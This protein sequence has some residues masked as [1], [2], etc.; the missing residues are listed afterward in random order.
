MKNSAHILI[1]GGGSG[2]GNGLACRLLKRGGNISVLDLAVSSDYRQALDAAAKT[3]QGNWAFFEIDICDAEKVNK[4]VN[5]A[6]TKFGDIQLAINSA[7]IAVNQLAEETTAAT[8]SKVIDINLKG[9]FNFASAVLPTLKPGGRLA[10]VASMAGI[11]GNYGY[12]AYSASKFGVVGL[13]NTLRN[14]YEPQGI[15]ISCVYP[16][17]VRTP[18]VEQEHAT[19]NP[20]SLELK[21]FAGSLD[22]DDA[23]NQILNSLD[24]GRWMIIPGHKAKI[25]AFAARHIPGIFGAINLLL[26]KL[27]LRKHRR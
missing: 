19:G 8:F 7:G 18:M 1:S 27:M 3:G 2:L 16:P 24:K 25:T 14:E 6:I 12:S 13:A 22:A 17:E 10:L 5:G 26:V 20:I 21:K 11:I 23:C 4:A 15:H 9:S